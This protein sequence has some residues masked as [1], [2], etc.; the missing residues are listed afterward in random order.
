[1]AQVIEFPG[2]GG[3]ATSL[4]AEP[5]GITRV[6]AERVKQLRNS[7]RLTLAELAR[8]TGVSERTIHRIESGKTSPRKFTL[9]RLSKRGFK[10]D[11]EVLTGGKPLPSDI[12]QLSKPADEASYQ[13]NVRLQP[14]IRNAYELTARQ[15]GVSVQKLAQLAPLMFVILA[16]KSLENLSRKV[17]EYWESREKFKKSNSELPDLKYCTYLDERDSDIEA[18]DKSISEKDLFGRSLWKDTP[19]EDWDQDNPF[20]TYLKVLMA[21]RDDISISAVGPISTNYRVC[22]A[23]AMELVGNDQ[24]AAERLLSGQVAIDKDFRRLK[25]AEE[26]VKW[27][28]ENQI[29]ES[30]MEDQ[31]QEKAPEE[32]WPVD[33]ALIASDLIEF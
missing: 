6:I 29:P 13:F 28:C 25:T 20:C 10:I 19:P 4:G 14:A 17:D 7:H 31:I 33:E 9:E 2:A 12:N 26:R 27:I 21:G 11:P 22:R 1:M 8:I 32:T 16:E 5:T 30:E 24:N 15:Y 23:E 18:I 3:M